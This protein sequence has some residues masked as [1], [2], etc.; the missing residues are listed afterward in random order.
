MFYHFSGLRKL[1]LTRYGRYREDDNSSLLHISTFF[2]ESALSHHGKR[3]KNVIAK[4][5]QSLK[6][7]FRS[8]WTICLVAHRVCLSWNEIMKSIE[9]GTIAVTLIYLLFYNGL[10]GFCDVFLWKPCSSV[11]P[12]ESV[13]LS[14]FTVRCE[15][16]WCYN[17]GQNAELN[18]EFNQLASS[19]LKNLK[20]VLSIKTIFIVDDVEFL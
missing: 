17:P 12:Q 18:H 20:P 2:W 11:S 14:L 3:F 15:D 4:N 10:A 13:T 8:G 9:S 7:S 19:F 6:F 1:Y 5:T 16:C